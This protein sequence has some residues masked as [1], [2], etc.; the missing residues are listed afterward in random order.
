LITETELANRIDAATS[1][2]SAAPRE[3]I[4]AADALTAR[5]ATIER[6]LER[7]H[8]TLEDVRISPR[9]RPG[10][11]FVVREGPLALVAVLVASLG[12][13]AHWIP[14]RLARVVAMRSIGDDRSRDQPAMRTILFGLLF[15][16]LW[17]A[18]IAVVLARLI[19]PVPAL[20]GLVVIFSAAHADRLLHGRLRRAV[21]RARSYLALRRNPA[22]QGRAIAEIDA[23]LAEALMLEH[24]LSSGAGGVV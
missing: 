17:Y 22:L 7:R 4:E 20:L 10:V 5:L 1:V 14:L 12:R 15:V 16:T 23:L 21:Q 24:T 9:V 11:R 13:V 19:G 3:T 18:A 6:E 2:L 8:I